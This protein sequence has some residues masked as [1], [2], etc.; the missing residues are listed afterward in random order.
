MKTFFSLTLISLLI[1]GSFNDTQAQ[2]GRNNSGSSG[3]G[4]RG[5][6]FSGNRNVR[7][8]AP[9]RSFRDY[10]NNISRNNS[11]SRSERTF[12]RSTVN[13]NNIQNRN[14]RSTSRTITNNNTQRNNNNQRNQIARNDLRD[15]RISS[16]PR[17]QRINSV[18]NS[19]YN[20]NGVDY[21]YNDYRRTYQYN[22]R[23]YGGGYYNFNNRRYCFMYGPRYTVI[24]RSYVSIHFGGY[25]YYY[26]DGFF[27]GYYSGYYQPIFPPIGIRIGILPFGYS[28][29]FIGSYPYYYYNG[30]YYRQYDHDN[31]EVVDPPMGAT[32]YNLPEGVKSVLI[33]GE[34]MYEL[35]GTYYKEEKNSK[36]KVIYTV[37]GRN[38]EVN[39]TDDESTDS[40]Q[41]P[42]QDGDI[43]N[44]LPEG[45]KVVTINGEKMYVTPDDTYLKEENDGDAVHYKVVGH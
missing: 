28:R 6:T 7:S 36:G 25:P 42:L 26:N 39:N 24:P 14:E 18:G 16:V 3:N 27:Y 9:E 43:V 45:S 21:R 30:I 12:Q 8:N 4:N 37:V 44:Q 10:N 13:R 38:G 32:V 29:V 17:T 15:T 40:L 22:N 2:R 35:N 41:S 19:G 5:E 33:N 20:R 31:Y 1:F 11:T 34:K 23:Y